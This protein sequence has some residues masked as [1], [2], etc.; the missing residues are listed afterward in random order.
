MVHFGDVR[1]FAVMMIILAAIRR[2]ILKA[3]ETK[4]VRREKH[5]FLPFT[6][7]LLPPFRSL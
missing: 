4:D 3:G 7:Y 6:S 5:P 1:I 2:M